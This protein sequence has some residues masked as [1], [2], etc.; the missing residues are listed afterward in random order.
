MLRTAFVLLIVAFG[1]RHALRGP[2]YA[3]MFYLWV[4]YFRPETWVWSGFVQD[5]PLSFFVGALVVVTGVVTGQALRLSARGMLLVLF[6]IHSLISTLASPYIAYGWPYWMDFLKSTLMTYLLCVLV[7]SVSRLRLAF[8]V[9]TLSL[10]FEAAK[11]G[12]VQLIFIPGEKNYN[13]MLSLGDNNGVAIG[14]LLLVTMIVALIQTS[15]KRWQRYTLVALL[16]GILYRAISTY[17]RGGLVACAVMALMYMLRAKH[18]VRT[19]LVVAVATAA[20]APVLSS[21]YWDRIASIRLPS[22]D[23]DFTKATSA[24]DS[25]TMSRLHFW[26]VALEMAKRNPFL[27][28]GHN[29]FVAAYDDYDTSNG[30][31][32]KRRSVH[33][34][35]FGLLAELGFPGLII[36]LAIWGLGILGTARVLWLARGDPTF[37]DLVPYAVALQ[38]AMIV[39]AVGGAFVIFQYTEMGWHV[40]GL[41]VAISRIA[42]ARLRAKADTRVEQPAVLRPLSSQGVA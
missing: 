9:I 40:F 35:W 10:G 27:G 23:E 2:F 30:A 25:S 36:Y 39:F 33:S 28:V 26:K 18:K 21:A 37:A 42:S 11:S 20:I 17:S 32:G 4:A 6:L 16:F 5:L 38:T 12:L 19:F 1:L 41:S 8:L 34:L 29:S 7:D 31:F 24:D 15:T 3:L 14:M 22:A 13:E